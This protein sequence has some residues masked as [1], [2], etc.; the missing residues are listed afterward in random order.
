MDIVLWSG[1]GVVDVGSGVTRDID[2]RPRRSKPTAEHDA[3][4][5]IE[6]CYGLSI[7]RRWGLLERI[8]K[9]HQDSYFDPTA[10]KCNPSLGNFPV[11]SIPS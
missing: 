8:S 3:I 9:E 4:T 10:R 6:R 5:G 1:S 11:S 2:G 7:A